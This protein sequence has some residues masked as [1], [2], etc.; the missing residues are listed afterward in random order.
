MKRKLPVLSVYNKT[1][2]K[3]NVDVQKL[4]LRQQDAPENVI[5][6]EDMQDLGDG[7]VLEFSPYVQNNRGVFQKASENI[8]V[9][10]PE[11]VKL[12]PVGMAE[13]YGLTPGELAGKSDFE[14]MVDQQALRQRIDN[15]RQ[16]RIEIEG[17]IFF[18]EMFVGKLNPKDEFLSNGI[19]FDDVWDHYNEDRKAY[20]ITYNPK[21]FEFQR[22]DYNNITAIPTDLV[23]VSFPHESELD[24]VGFNRKWGCPETEGLKWTNVK[25]DFKAERID[26]KDTAM[27]EIIR[28]NKRRIRQ[29]SQEQ[30]PSPVRKQRGPR[31]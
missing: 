11:L 9:R 21:T 30:R 28:F 22:P 17:H 23:V 13:K 16:P 4:E 2:T 7:Y 29:I 18:V 5:R 20:M 26:W 19:V 10:I 15:G 3:F 14:V 24:P 8:T 6:F 25:L 12:D 31:P 27:P 1:V